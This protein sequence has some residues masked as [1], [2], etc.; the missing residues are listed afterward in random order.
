MQREAEKL[1]NT[2][3]TK[4]GQLISEKTQN[5]L[6]CERYDVTTAPDGTV[7]GVTQPY[8]TT[9]LKIPYTQEVAGAAVGD[10]VIVFWWGSLSTA[11]AWCYGNGLKL[12]LNGSG[13]SSS[14]PIVKPLHFNGTI[15][16][17]YNLS[18]AETASCTVS[19]E[20]QD[21]TIYSS[22]SGT[23]TWSQKLNTNIATQ[24][25]NSL[26]GVATGLTR[27]EISCLGQYSV[28]KLWYK[29]TGEALVNV[30]GAS[31]GSVTKLWVNS[32]PTTAVTAPVVNFTYNGYDFYILQHRKATTNAYTVTTPIVGM[33]YGSVQLFSV[34]ANVN[35]YSAYRDGY[36]TL[37]GSNVQV[38]FGNAWYYATYG[39]NTTTINSSFLIPT[40]IWGVKL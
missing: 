24:P 18:V 16:D 12:G 7:I 26:I 15:L 23:G 21:R 27:M 20:S 35:G 37:S 4:C 13:K 5:C 40:Y 19:P 10:T 36:I 30:K 17:V 22:I 34:N 3:K 39:T 11:K 9:E 25:N 29:F 31:G 14:D 38:S 33:K 28:D 32:A 2:I 1:I 6:R 8:G